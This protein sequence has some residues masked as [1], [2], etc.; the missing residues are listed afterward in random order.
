MVGKKLSMDLI[1]L[2]I[3]I[4]ALVLCQDF[5]SFSIFHL[6]FYWLVILA[7]AL[8]EAHYRLSKI[9]TD[10]DDP[11]VFRTLFHCVSSR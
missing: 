5:S 4:S 1:L 11:G 9:T 3:Y 2:F 8:A 10:P 7:S 6:V